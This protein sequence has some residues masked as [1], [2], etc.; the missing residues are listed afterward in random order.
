MLFSPEILQR[1]SMFSHVVIHEDY[2]Q[3]LLQ[4][5]KLFSPHSNSLSTL[6]TPIWVGREKENWAFGWS[7]DIPKI[8]LCLSSSL[9]FL[10]GQCSLTCFVSVFSLP[11][12]FLSFHL[13]SKSSPFLS[14]LQSRICF[15]PL[16]NSSTKSTLNS[17]ALSRWSSYHCLYAITLVRYNSFG[18][19]LIFSITLHSC[20]L[21][22]IGPSFFFSQALCPPL[23][24]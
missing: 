13:Q 9:L 22:L 21:V 8:S 20:L 24:I 3:V 18:N 6:S 2:G 12:H 19:S 5:F 4:A 10:P 11:N 15:P 14:L 17:P 1:V 23:M 16:L 7:S